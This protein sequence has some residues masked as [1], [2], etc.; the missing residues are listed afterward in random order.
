MPFIVVPL[1]SNPRRPFNSCILLRNASDS[2]WHAVVT[3]DG[4]EMLFDV[5]GSDDKVLPVYHSDFSIRLFISLHTEKI[6]EN[7]QFTTQDTVPHFGRGDDLARFY[8]MIASNPWYPPN[9]NNP[10]LVVSVSRPGRT[11]QRQL[12]RG[13]FCILPCQTNHSNQLHRGILDVP[14]R[15]LVSSPCRIHE[16]NQRGV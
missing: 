8:T 14:D 3:R 12:L 15:C 11:E 2:L 13:S 4:M 6:C 1:D 9:T 10:P 7:S 5:T 16:S